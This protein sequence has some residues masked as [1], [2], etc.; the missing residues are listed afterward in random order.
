MTFHRSNN[1]NLDQGSANFFFKE[2]DSKCVG[3]CWPHMAFVAYSLLKNVKTTLNLKAAREKQATG[4]T[5]LQ[6]IVCQPPVL[7]HTAI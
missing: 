3:L 5:G 6:T 4:Q 7:L 2:L 1:N